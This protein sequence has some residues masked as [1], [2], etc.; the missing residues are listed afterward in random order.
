VG[1]W[2]LNGLKVRRNQRGRTIHYWPLPHS[3]PQGRALA[4]AA[5][6][7]LIRYRVSSVWLILAG[8]AIGVLDHYLR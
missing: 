3:S 6:V 1:S 8:G 5:A 7:L 2:V 4:A